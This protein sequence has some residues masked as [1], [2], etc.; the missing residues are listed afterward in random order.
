MS[1]QP[2]HTEEYISKILDQYSDL[3]YRIALSKQQRHTQEVYRAVF[4]RLMELSVPFEDEA[5]QKDWLI[6]TAIQS[7]RKISFSA[8][9]RYREKPD[10]HSIFRAPEQTELPAELLAYDTTDRIIVYLYYIEEYDWAA[11]ARFL[12]QKESEVNERLSHL[13]RDFSVEAEQE[14]D[15]E[16]KVLAAFQGVHAPKRLVAK[17]AEEM[18]F[19][20]RGK[21]AV[22]KYVV[23]AAAVVLVIAGLIILPKLE[24]SGSAR[25]QGTESA[26]PAQAAETEKGVTFSLYLD[27]GENSLE[28]QI[29]ADGT[30]VSVPKNGLYS[31]S[32]SG[33]SSDGKQM[34]LEDYFDFNLR[35][36]GRTDIKRVTYTAVNCEFIKKIFFAEAQVKSREAYR[37]TDGTIWN[38]DQGNGMTVSYGFTPIGY[39][40]SANFLEQASAINFGLK[41]SY[42]EE[43]S[44]ES[45]PDQV[46]WEKLSANSQK[47]YEKMCIQADIE[48]ESGSVLHRTVRFSRNGNDIRVWVEQ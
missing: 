11:I 29:P 31:I 21:Q 5:G 19:G 23:G 6:R 44:N 10:E 41:T 39:V 7:S 8:L 20:R 13:Q 32:G 28:T 18:R 25:T 37:Y 47:A 46:D 48:L 42:T 14:E 36:S 1:V 4:L 9:L 24:N 30:A 12:N 16:N 17:T 27:E 38:S 22:I 35:S 45:P 40:Y 15:G 2:E 43:A 33:G 3:V 34:Q 26:Q